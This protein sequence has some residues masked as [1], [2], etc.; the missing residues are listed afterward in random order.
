[1]QKCKNK[2]GGRDN[3]E[4]SAL[5]RYKSPTLGDLILS[6]AIP[7]SELLSVHALSSSTNLLRNRLPRSISHYPISRYELGTVTEAKQIEDQ[8]IRIVS[9]RAIFEIQAFDDGLA[10]N[11]G[12]AHLTVI[13][14]DLE[15]MVGQ[16]I[17]SLVK[18][19]DSKLEA[20]KA[21]Y[22]E[23]PDLSSSASYDVY[24]FEMKNGE[25]VRILGSHFHNGYY[26]G[27][28]FLMRENNPFYAAVVNSQARVVLVL[29]L[30]ASGKTTFCQ[31][32]FDDKAFYVFDD[33]LF[34]AASEIVLSKLLAKGQKSSMI[35]MLIIIET[36]LTSTSNDWLIGTMIRL[37]TSSLWNSGSD[38]KNMCLR[39]MKDSK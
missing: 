29:G 31:S 24:V 35:R 1:M 4:S 22:P 11:D 8:H 25:R 39:V 30:P 26:S 20:F 6:K 10:G 23:C 5:Y 33:P 37:L 13:E 15:K 27:G 9:D 3:T 16:E 38:T 12:H 2:S 7:S 19:D 18:S 14:G 32:H 21:L 28:S 34:S 17:V 36:T